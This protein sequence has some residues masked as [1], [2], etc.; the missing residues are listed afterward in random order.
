MNRSITR[1]LSTLLLLSTSVTCWAA[2]PSRGLWV[3]EVALNAVNEAT[4]AVGDS[5]TYEFTDPE[6]ATSTSDTAFLRVIVHVNGAGQAELLK[7][8]A[9]YE[10]STDTYGE[11]DILLI[12]NPALYSNYPGIARRIASAFYDFGDASSVDAVQL[13]IDTSVDKAVTDVF[14]GI[15]SE[16]TLEDLVDETNQD[17]LL[18]VIVNNADVQTAYLDRSGSASFITDDFFDLAQVLLLSDA[19]AESVDAGTD[20]SAYEYEYDASTPYTPFSLSP[21]PLSPIPPT[22]SEFD[23]VRDAA[24]A[25]VTASFY[26]DTRGIDAVVNIIVAAANGATGADL[27]EKQ[28]NAFLAAEAAWHNAADLTQAYNRF[29]AGSAYASLEDLLPPLAASEAVLALARSSV[30]SVIADEVEDA[31]LGNT[32]VQTAY[33]EAATIFAESLNS[34]TRAQLVLERLISQTAAAVAAQVLID[35]EL[36]GLTEVANLALGNALADVQTSPVLPSAP[37]ELYSDFVRDDD[38][39]EAASLAAETAVNEAHFQFD[40]GLD[41]ASIGSTDEA[42][43]RLLVKAKVSKALAAIRNDAA[44]LPIF[45]VKLDGSLAAGGALTGEIY[46]P[47]LAPSNPFLH[48]LHPDHTEGF[49]ITRL[50]SMS[51]DTVDGGG[52]YVEAG[53]GVSQ[54]TGTYSEEIFGLH[55]PL[56]PQKDIGLKTSGSFTLNR[57]TFVDTLN[58]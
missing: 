52:N 41:D 34:D 22:G 5:N 15:D 28:A 50:I 4:G 1:N 53:Y 49:P 20:P 17:G 23:A 36:I 51:V 18:D 56:G 8:V 54:L 39:S 45:S 57:L 38:F 2:H 58:F 43:M 31:L 16:V 26:G 12:T 48:R 14:A 44:A 35:P 46:L 11:S 55:K 6:I 42:D 19:V 24:V 7:S 27:A 9:L 32:E 13:L 29:L 37:S 21:S 47:A 30:E 10:N 25:L 33:S 3:G 40:N